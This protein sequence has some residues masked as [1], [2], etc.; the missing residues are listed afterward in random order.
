MDPESQV[1]E[2]VIENES[3][4]APQIMGR[5]ADNPEA[6]RQIAEMPV[7]QRDRWLGALEDNIMA[8]ANFR[9]QLA[10]Q[11]QQWNQERKVTRAP[12]V[13]RSPRG[14]PAK[15]SA[16]LPGLRQLGAGAKSTGLSS[17]RWSDRDSSAYKLRTPLMALLRDAESQ[18]RWP[19]SIQKRTRGD[20]AAL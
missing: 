20:C 16:L 9:Q 11:Q 5:L 19:P 12:P 1:A 6:L 8:E 7:R 4:V 17:S 10:Q 18:E 3:V 14:E 13:I 15:H 2:W